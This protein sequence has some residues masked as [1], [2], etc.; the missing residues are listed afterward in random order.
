MSNSLSFK[1]SYSYNV[2]S[3]VCDATKTYRAQEVHPTYQDSHL[4]SALSNDC[5]GEEASTK[6][7][8]KTRI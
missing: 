6:L 2:L 8:E 1:K 5:I 7:N 3:T 4:F